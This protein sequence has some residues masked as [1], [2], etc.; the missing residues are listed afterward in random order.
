[1]GYEP[2]VIDNREPSPWVEMTRADAE[3]WWRRNPG[4]PVSA[5]ADWVEGYYLPH[6]ESGMGFRSG[7]QVTALLQEGLDDV[8]ITLHEV[9]VREQ[10]RRRARRRRA[11]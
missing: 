1:M 4:E 9:L 8:H 2:S 5:F 7:Y 3:D 6:I 11:A 10:E